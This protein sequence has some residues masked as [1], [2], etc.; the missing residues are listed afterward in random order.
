MGERCAQLLQDGMPT[1]GSKRWQRQL[2]VGRAQQL[3]YQISQ[4]MNG[5]GLFHSILVIV[6]IADRDVTS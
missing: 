4:Q 1:I 3:L 6:P 5:H 2:D